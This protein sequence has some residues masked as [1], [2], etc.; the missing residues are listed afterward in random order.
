MKKSKMGIHADQQ[1]NR[2]V[3]Y[4]IGIDIFNSISVKNINFFN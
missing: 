3:F 2:F 4:D 1:I